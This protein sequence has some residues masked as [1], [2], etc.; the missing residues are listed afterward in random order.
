MSGAMPACSQ[1]RKVPV[2]PQP[3]ITSSAIS[4]TPWAAQMRHFGQHM[5]RVEQHT[6][7]AEDQ[8]LNDEGGGVGAAFALQRIIGGLFGAGVRNGITP[9]SKSSG[10]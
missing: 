2:R 1:A 3:V 7:R 10:S 5:R 4:K 8:R 9:T 6:A